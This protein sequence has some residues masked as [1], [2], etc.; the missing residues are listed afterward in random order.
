M[1]EKWTYNNKDY[2]SVDGYVFDGTKWISIS[3][4]TELLEMMSKEYED[5]SI[6]DCT[7]MDGLDPDEEIQDWFTF[8]E[9]KI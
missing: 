6:W 7:L 5:M 9:N 1:L 3:E 8:K 4:Y 2:I